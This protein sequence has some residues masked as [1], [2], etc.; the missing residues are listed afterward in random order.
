MVNQRSTTKLEPCPCGGGALEKCCEP[1]I[2]GAQHAVSAE[3][4]MRSRYSA[5]VLGEENYL[6]ASWPKT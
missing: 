3:Q 1:F 5:Y 2:S 6:R 4:L